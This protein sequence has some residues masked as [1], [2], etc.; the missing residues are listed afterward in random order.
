MQH[1]TLTTQPSWLNRVLRRIL[2]F[3]VKTHVKPLPVNGLQFEITGRGV[4][5]RLSSLLGNP[6]IAKSLPK[7]SDPT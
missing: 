4:R 3:C 7:D 6:A 1:T 5:L 2:T